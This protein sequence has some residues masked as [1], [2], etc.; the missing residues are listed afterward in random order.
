MERLN[1]NITRRFD[2]MANYMMLL[3][4]ALSHSF[5][6]YPSNISLTFRNVQLYSEG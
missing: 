5:P 6:T 1:V 2:D 3:G 4:S